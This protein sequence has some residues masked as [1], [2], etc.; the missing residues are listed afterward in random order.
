[1]MFEKELRTAVKYFEYSK[2]VAIIN[3]IC[4]HELSTHYQVTD[5]EDAFYWILDA[6]IVEHEN[7]LGNK[8][9]IKG[10]GIWAE[11][12]QRS[13]IVGQDTSRH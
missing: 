1:M 4:K 8:L 7:S 6:K 3:K 9:K 13:Y 12:I 5:E 10:S 2:A 11:V